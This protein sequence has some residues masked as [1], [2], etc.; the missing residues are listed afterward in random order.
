MKRERTF[1]EYASLS[2]MFVALWVIVWVLLKEIASV[3][4]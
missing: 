4:A 3:F 1:L 2:F